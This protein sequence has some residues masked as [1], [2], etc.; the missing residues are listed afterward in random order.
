MSNVYINYVTKLPKKEKEKSPNHD[1]L[2]GGI[3]L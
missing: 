3:Y 2:G 1:S